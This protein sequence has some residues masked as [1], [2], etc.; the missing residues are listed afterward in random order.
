MATIFTSCYLLRL[1]SELLIQILGHL[2][3]SLHSQPD[4]Y[5]SAL[6]PAIPGM[7]GTPGNSHLCKVAAVCHTLKDLAEPFIYKTLCVNFQRPKAEHLH[8]T[9][10]SRP[11]LWPFCLKLT[12][13][14]AY[15]PLAD[16][17]AKWLTNVTELS[18][19]GDESGDFLSVAVG[20]APGLQVLRIIND[21]QSCEEMPLSKS[22]N[23]VSGAD[24]ME[25]LRLLQIRAV[26]QEFTSEDRNKLTVWLSKQL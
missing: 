3:S 2:T 6:W 11:H 20:H 26:S 7:G 1:P 22:V 4:E 9:L 23:A 25:S 5:E 21:D 10:K 8:R 17:F 15:S 12:L 18:I 24:N 14:G 19:L 13:V 16:E